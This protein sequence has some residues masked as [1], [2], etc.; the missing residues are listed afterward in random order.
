MTR[1]PLGFRYGGEHIGGQYQG[2]VSKAGYIWSRWVS[3]SIVGNNNNF[4][5]RTCGDCNT[6]IVKSF[7]ELM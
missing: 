4:F 2:E 6:I 7:T 3:V 5:A 1:I